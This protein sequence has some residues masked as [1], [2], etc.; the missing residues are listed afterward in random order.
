MARKLGSLTL[1]ILLA[2]SAWASARPGTISGYVRNVKGVPQM[3]AT[4]HITAAKAPLPVTVFTDEQ[5][6]FKAGGLDPGT[7]SVKVSAASF[8]PTLR[9]K[10]QLSSGAALVV[11]L[12]LATLFEAVQLA[13]A[14]DPAASEEDDWK[15]TLRSTGNRSILRVLPNSTVAVVSE[16]D[17]TLEGTVAFYAGS[18]RQGFGSAGEMTTAFAIEQ[19]LFS[20]RFWFDGNFATSAAAPGGVFRAT[21]AREVGGNSQP[22]V[23]L[24]V[25]HLASPGAATRNAALDALELSLRNR[26]VMDDLLELNYGGMLQSIQFGSRVTVFRPFASVRANLWPDTYVEYRYT[27]SQPNTRHWKGHD[28]APADLSESGPQM[29]LRE[30][31]PVLEKA[32][33]QEI[34]VN[35]KYGDYNVQIA[36]YYDQVRDAAL[37]GVGEVSDPAGE[38]LPDVYSGT[39]SYNGGALNTKGIRVVVQRKFGNMTATADYAFGGVITAGLSG[40]DLDA[41]QDSFRTVKAHAV[42]TQLSGNVPRL[43]TRWI[44]T[45]KWTSEESLTPVDLFN[46]S[47]GQADPYLSIFLRQPLPMA[48]IGSGKLEAIIDLRNLLAQGYLPVLAKD[49]SKMYLVQAARSVRGGVAFNF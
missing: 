2:T 45:Y 22:Q 38:L 37:L 14:V 19:S 15:W 30:H 12:T 7:Y 20:G 16:A 39:F 28:T 35:H 49:G 44:T 46:E 1:V 6:F 8:L 11:N 24:T 42:S 34:A 48:G 21:Y 40:A 27:T 33:H 31:A 3:G 26:T 25:R 23:A 32:R 5:G 18:E 13:P 10:V 17:G 4:V 29:S 9:E 43:K 47:P 41:V 36:A